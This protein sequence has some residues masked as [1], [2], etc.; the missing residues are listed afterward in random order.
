MNITFVCT[1]ESE[2][3][4]RGAKQICVCIKTAKGWGR[5]ARARE[6]ALTADCEKSLLEGLEV[7]AQ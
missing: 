5:E 3:S 1:A 2:H 6:V 4:E 7:E